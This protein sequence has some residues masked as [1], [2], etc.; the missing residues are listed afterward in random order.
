MMSMF[1]AFVWLG[2]IYSA[3]LREKETGKNAFYSFWE[4][5]CWPWGMGRYIAYHFYLSDYERK[6]QEGGDRP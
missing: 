4:A 1:I 2:G 5:I 6:S 3:F